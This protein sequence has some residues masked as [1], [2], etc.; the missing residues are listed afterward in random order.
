MKERLTG[1]IILVA[2]IVCLVPELLKGPVRS[3]P[4]P[5]D[6]S[7][8]GSSLRSITFDVAADEARSSAT[9]ASSGPPAPTPVEPA[10]TPAPAAPVQ[11]ANS[12]PAAEPDVAPA[13]A[14]S[15]PPSAAPAPHAKPSV[16]K[17]ATH[18]PA[19]SAHGWLVQVGSFAQRGNAEH[20]AQ[21]LT[22]Q[23]FASSVSQSSGG[24]HLY[25]VRV[26]PVHD[27]AAATQLAAK[28]RAAGH[29]GSLVSD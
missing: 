29:K 18:A 8:E 2:L 5:V 12:S 21:Q 4:Q 14:S 7:A 17:P 13:P 26:G 28:L 6:A 10:A 15:P 27:K 20:L 22:G 1:A 11:G 3:A 16:A 9:T 19:P 24:R 25:R 23:G